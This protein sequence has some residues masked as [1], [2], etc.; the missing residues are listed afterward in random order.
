MKAKHSRQQ[1][2]STVEKITDKDCVLNS[3]KK[4]AN[5]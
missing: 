3:S 1:K 5:V 4:R 2:Q